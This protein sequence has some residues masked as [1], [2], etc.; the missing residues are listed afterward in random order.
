MKVIESTVP[1]PKNSYTFYQNIDDIV[2]FDIE[3]TG[4]SPKASSL[5]LIGAMSYDSAKKQWQLIQWFADDYQSEATLLQSF[6]EYLEPFQAL[7][8]FNGAVFDIP[9]I[10]SKC[11]KHNI[12]ISSHCR[13]LLEHT[14]SHQT[15]HICGGISVDLLREIRPLKKKLQLAK[16][17]QTALEKWLGI[18]REDQYNGGELISVY[19]EYMQ[20]KLLHREK[21]EEL[22]HLLLLH[23]HDDIA[24]MLE[25]CSILSYTDALSSPGRMLSCHPKEDTLQITFQTGAIVPKAI[26]IVKEIPFHSG[27][28]PEFSAE[29]SAS[30]SSPQEAF[31]TLE[32]N[33]AT[34]L[35]P[36]FQ[37][38]LKYFFPDYKNYYYL[39]QED[40]AIYKSVA[41]F[42]DPAFRQK[43]TA[44]TCYIKKEGLYL[45][46]LS[47]KKQEGDSPLFYSGY[48]SLPAYYLLDNAPEAQETSIQNYLR[49]EIPEF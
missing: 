36:V 46:S 29:P 18:H 10:Q 42:V 44:T 5:Y 32:E 45:P 15:A 24:G 1:A 37:G 20:A 6:F 31:L 40:T 22:E 43:A 21:A 41:E 25:V 17:N 34:L 27:K 49:R 19:A 23:N 2:F 7:Y 47:R 14:D 8:H 39:P 38:T 16:A 35:L 4:L 3:T 11:K 12:S 26:Q 9:Y 28:S 48:K 33:T 30:F 13:Q